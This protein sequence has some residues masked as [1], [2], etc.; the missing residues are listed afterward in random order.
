MI[1]ET[2]LSPCEHHTKTMCRLA[3]YFGNRTSLEKF[4]IAPDH[5]LYAQSWQP[6]EMSY[7]KL[8][9]DGFGFGWYPEL[10]RPTIYRSITPIWNDYNLPEISTVLTA[11]LWLAMV[12][13]IT[14]RGWHSPANTQPFRHGHYLF[15]HN[16]F[17]EGFNDGPRTKILAELSPEI[18]ANIKGLTDSEYLFAL[19]CQ[20]SKTRPD[21]LEPALRKVVRWCRRHLK[22][23][24]ILLNLIC[25]DGRQVVALRHA[26]KD[27]APTLYWT[28][29]A[30][31]F[32]PGSILVASEPF[33]ERGTWH[34]I[35]SG[36]CLT[37]RNYAAPEA[38]LATL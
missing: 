6:Q 16:G 19:F 25:T 15:V 11:P 33:S 4:L 30:E 26:Q 38:R 10:G 7:A 20:F 17:V 31:G 28:D 18:T 27:E 23:H 24:R 22:E 21:T 9:A 1:A 32:S 36:H 37:I 2:N 34:S 14:T 3:A 35:P 12:R 29:A 8:N 13:S 5:S